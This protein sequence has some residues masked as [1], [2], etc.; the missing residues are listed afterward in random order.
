MPY[1]S[2]DEGSEYG[3][4]E[5]QF[6]RLSEFIYSQCGI[7]MPPSKKTM[8]TA[9][10]QKRLRVLGLRSFA[11][12]VDWVLDPGSSDDELINFID[13]VTTNK[14]DFFREPSHFEYLVQNVLPELI[15]VEGA[16]V[17][18]PLTIWS[19]GCSTGEEPYT[20]A[21]VLQEFAERSPGINFTAQILATDISTRVLSKAQNA[22]YEMEKVQTIPLAMKRKYLLKSKDPMKKLVRF[23]PELRGMVRFRRLNFMDHDFGLR[24]KMD[25]V[26]CR[27][28]VIYFDR[29]TQEKLVNKFCRYMLP[30]AYLFMGHSETLNNLR[31]PVVQVAPTIYRLPK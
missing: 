2:D 24:E 8:L 4:S 31:V 7:M 28:V 27:N 12:Y 11:E 20:L 22:V 29:P 15:R 5:K 17:R 1:E 6:K 25:V 14:T 9:R 23:T 16:G 10:I 26:F 13:I 30:G 19:A 3:L 18:R 21:M